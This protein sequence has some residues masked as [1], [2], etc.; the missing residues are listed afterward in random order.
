MMTNGKPFLMLQLTRRSLS[1]STARMDEKPPP[2]GT[3]SSEASPD[4]KLAAKAA[5][6]A[7]IIQADG[8]DRQTLGMSIMAGLGMTCMFASWVG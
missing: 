2:F 7:A 5:Q 6:E 1:R 3:D 8:T 4:A